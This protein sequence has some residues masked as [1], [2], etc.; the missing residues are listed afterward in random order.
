MKIKNVFDEIFSIDNLYAALEDASQG[1]RYNKDALIYNLDVWAMVQEIRNEIFNG[2][3]SIDRYYIFYVY[4][5]KKR[6][7]MSISFKHRIVQW[8]IYRVINPV[9]VKGY[10]ED[11]YGCIPGRGSL[12]AMQRLKYWVVMAS[13]KEEQWF[14]LKLDISK[15]F[16]RISHRVL[17]KILAKKIKDKRLLKVLYSIIDCEHT[18]FGLPLGRS[19][20]DVPLEERLFDVGMPIGNLLSQL[21]AN[22]Y[23][24]ELDQYCK[25]ELQI[26]FYI[27][28]MDDVIIL[29]NSKLQLRIWK[30]Q[31]EQFLFG[32]MRLGTVVLL[33]AA[34]IFMWKTYKKVEAYFKDKYEMEAEKEKQMKDILGQVQQ[35]PKWR[36]Q[37]IERQKEFSSEIN[38]LR[39]TQ[40]EIIQELKDIEERRKKTKRNE[41]R[42]RLLQ[43]YRYYTSKD[44]NP[45]L[46]WSVMESD[47]F[48][49]MFG[50]YEEAGGD[51][52]MHTTVQPAM[53]LLDVIQMNE[54]ERISELMQS[55]K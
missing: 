38:D 6:M 32:G 19:P 2:T 18:P 40:K 46:A 41:L 14:Y 8:A 1:R 16:Y 45:L 31:I 43:S 42:D 28:Y 53:R 27:R 10:I 49:K 48:W 35:Y 52:D 30:D 47:A 37:S 34:F 11:S 23:L 55:R 3:Y 21:F 29:C 51:G 54:E 15:Y 39:N 9:L 7:I 12:S 26:R 33:I 5:P 13:R 20:G 4:E 50:D 44:K 24:N 36:E 25:R 17:K 22:V